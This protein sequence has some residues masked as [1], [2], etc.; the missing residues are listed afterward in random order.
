MRIFVPTT[1][2]ERY[3]AGRAARVAPLLDV[4][5]QVLADACGIFV[6]IGFV[7]SFITTQIRTQFPQIRGASVR[8]VQY[9]LNEL[10][11]RGEIERVR[12][13]ARTSTHGRPVVITRWRTVR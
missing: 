10:E 5:R 2:L 8:D 13:V 7:T 12:G 9:A 4:V 1:D 6:E 3:A 11:R